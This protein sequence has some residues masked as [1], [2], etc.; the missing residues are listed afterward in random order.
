MGSLISVDAVSS[1]VASGFGDKTAGSVTSEGCC[2]SVKLACD[3]LKKQMELVEARLEGQLG[4]LPEWM[5]LVQE[6]SHAGVDMQAKASYSLPGLL[7]AFCSA[8]RDC[9][10]SRRWEACSADCPSYRR[11]TLPCK[12]HRSKPIQDYIMKLKNC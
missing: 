9:N 4:Q 10:T 1:K 6:C 3:Q 12:R 11:Q 2:A 5:H 7:R 8:T